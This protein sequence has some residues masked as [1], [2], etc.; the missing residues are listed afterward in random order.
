MDF[1]KR[2][3]QYAEVIVK[4]GLNVQPGQRVLLGRSIFTGGGVPLV[5]APLARLIAKKAYQAGARLV[6]TIWD[7]DEMK[8]IRFQHAPRDSFSEFSKW[9]LDVTADYGDQGDPAV[10]IGGSDP[11]LLS[12]QDQDAIKA[13]QRAG[14]QHSQKVVDHISENALCWCGVV[15]PSAGWAAKVLPDVPENERMERMWELVFDMCRIKGDDPVAGWH[16]HIEN[17]VTRATY[18]NEKQYAALHLKGPGTD[19]RIGLPPGHVWRSAGF[20]SKG[21]IPF[22]ANIPTEEVFT[23]P[24]RDQVEGMVTSTKPLNLGG[25]QIENFTLMFE[26]GRV[27]NAEAEAGQD[28]LMHLLDTDEGSRRTGEIALVPNSSPISQSGR[29]FYNILYDENASNH[30]ALGNAYRFSLEGGPEMSAE[31]FTAQGGNNSQVHVD[32]MVGSGEMSVDG[33]TTGGDVEA[34][35]RAGEWVI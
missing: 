34:V 15:Y 30:I 27:V 11:D 29:V 24:H 4:I 26:G 18:L 9:R 33:I 13:W 8:L 12:G 6:D 2:L 22:V 19:L 5:A 7:D 32:F 31:G 3:E 16:K 20:K 17:L 25:T 21:G 23:L 10:S 28:Q 35:M 1:E 14:Y